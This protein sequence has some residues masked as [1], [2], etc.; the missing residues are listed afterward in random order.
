VVRAGLEE[1][2]PNQGGW[3]R[4][5]DG[6]SGKLT[7]EEEEDGS[8]MK[9]EV[10]HVLSSENPIFFNSGLLFFPVVMQVTCWVAT[11]AHRTRAV[12]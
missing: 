6:R 3:R 9:K 7:R 4:S 11:E 10:Q 12:I 2:R 1:I 8:I 5:Q